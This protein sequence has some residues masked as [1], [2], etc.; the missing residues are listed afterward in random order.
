MSRLREDNFGNDG[1]RAYLGML[2]ANPGVNANALRPYPGFGNIY[3]F[4]TGANYVYNSLQSQFRRQDGRIAFGNLIVTSFGGAPPLTR[5][6][7][8]ERSRGNAPRRRMAARILADLAQ[9]WSIKDLIGL[10]QDADPEVRSQAAAGLRRLTGHTFGMDPAQ[11]RT[12][13][14]AACGRATES[15]QAWWEK[16]QF[17]CPSEPPNPPGGVK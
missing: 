10:L 6:L 16:N 13:S 4:N 12:A 8:S 2:T 14:P 15:W 5:Y 7:Q 9:P 3:E 1:A 17:R 11:W